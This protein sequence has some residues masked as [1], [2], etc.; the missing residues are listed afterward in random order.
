MP[1]RVRR[2]L[3]GGAGSR[4]RHD[5]IDPHRYLILITLPAHASKAASKRRKA[6]VRSING[7]L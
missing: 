7:Q 4:P 1:R 3:G 6:G 2:V 5:A